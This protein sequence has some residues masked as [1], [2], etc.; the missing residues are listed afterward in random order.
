MVIERLHR[1]VQEHERRLFYWIP[2]PGVIK[3]NE[4]A[5]ANAKAGLYSDELYKY[6]Q[7]L[8]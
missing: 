6:S 2:S 1:L 4:K 8:K 3:G 7:F 5:D